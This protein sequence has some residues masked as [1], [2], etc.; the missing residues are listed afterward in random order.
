MPK[1]IIGYV[2]DGEVEIE[3]ANAEEANAIF[4]KF[5][6]RQLTERGELF[7]FDPETRE[8]RAAWSAE[9]AAKVALAG[10]TIQ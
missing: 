3:A 8:E 10:A 2:I 1:Y 9:Q 7:A 5:G 4:Q 6:K